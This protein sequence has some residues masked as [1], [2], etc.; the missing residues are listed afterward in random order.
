MAQQLDTLAIDNVST[1]LNVV[2]SPHDMQDSDLRTATN[3]TYRPSGEA[4]SIDGLLQIGNPI[5]VNGTA[6]TKLLG[7]VRFQS[8]PYIMASNGNEARLLYK[9]TT[10]TGS[11]T[12]FAD[13][14]SG[15]VTVTSA[16]HGLSTNDV[17]TITGTT[18]YNG[19][20]TIANATTNTFEITDTWVSDDATG[21]WTSTGWT[22]VSATNFDADAKVD[23]IVYASQIWFVNGLATGGNTLH[24][25]NT[26]NTLSGDAT[27]P[28][29]VNRIALHLERIWISKGNT[30]YVTRQ[31]P[32]GTSADWD[33]SR[34][35][36][37]SDAPGEIKLDNNT[38]D[39]IQ[40]M[41]SNFGQLVV[42]RE[43]RIHVVVGKSILT[44][45]I[46]KSFNAR[47]TIAWSSV[48]KSDIAI[49]FLAR[50]GVKQLR[51]VTVQD[52][53]NEFD[54]ITSVGLDRK[55]RTDIEAFSDQSLSV[56][57]AFKDKYYL[58]NGSSLIYV[59]D[60]ITGGWS[61]WDENGAEFFL[62]EGDDLFCGIGD[63]YY[64]IDADATTSLTSQI[65]TKDY[66]LKTDRIQ[67]L[68]EKLIATLKTFSTDM[69]ITLE[70][71]IDGATTA[72][73]TKS[74]TVLSSDVKW[75]GSYTWD[76]GIR[77]DAGTVI[78]SQ[79]SQ[80]KLSSG[81]TIAF[82]VKATGTNRFSISAFNLAFEYLRRET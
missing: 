81:T 66:N 58:S 11:I 48:S 32:N 45:T 51:G 73:G 50:E 78:F 68:F 38:E 8:L 17:V 31:F 27:L 75:D 19:T 37:G 67:K 71:F 43:M 57:Y 35:Y 20:F 28:T 26:S 29:G 55:I 41:V 40:K 47:G 44:S 18:N 77:W 56:G 53:T 46:E 23:F 54:S 5:Q 2:D 82:G 3:V 64:Q 15:Q 9:D 33:T 14:G 65:R 1:G 12:A 80:R 69:T 36:A 24:Y 22:E 25:V 59:F 4:E 60:E 63:K 42:F 62:E 13:A 39:S 10:L 61:K 74:L 34:V 76:S 49:Y 52:K 21:T 79:H 70:W 30:I 16:S 6:A 7:A 72:T